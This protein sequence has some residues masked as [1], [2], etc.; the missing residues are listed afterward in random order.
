MKTKTALRYCLILVKN[1][2]NLKNKNQL[3]HDSHCVPN[4]RENEGRT[5]KV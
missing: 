2:C 4:T 3:E 5:V 1:V